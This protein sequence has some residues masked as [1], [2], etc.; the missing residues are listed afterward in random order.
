MI[1]AFHKDSDTQVWLAGEWH[2]E[3]TGLVVPVRGL[4][5]IAPR[6]ESE[7]ALCLADLKTTRSAAVL[8]WQRWCYQAR[9]HW[10][11]AL[12]IALWNAATGEERNTFCFIVQE[13]FAPWQTGK[14]ML[15]QDFLTLGT[16]EYRA[17]LANYCQCLKHDRWPGYDDTDEAIQSWSLV[18]PEPFM[19]ERAQFA[20]K[21][22][23]DE[24]EPVDE[25][26]AGPEFE[27]RD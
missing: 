20:P 5:D 15:S 9:Y 2:D 18:Q 12:Y 16:A 7:F 8:P 3:P 24:P 6:A 17:A 27:Y 14:R 23:F 22:D 11:A 4:V 19:A 26:K 1:A 13:N 25:Q 10:Q 21:Y